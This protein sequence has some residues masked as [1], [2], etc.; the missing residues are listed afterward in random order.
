MNIIQS[1]TNV[2]DKIQEFFAFID[3]VLFEI[4]FSVLWNWLPFPSDI[5]AVLVGLMFVVLVMAGVGFVKK[6][7]VLLG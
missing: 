3:G 2:V 7:V 6:I 4:D 1:L 5:S